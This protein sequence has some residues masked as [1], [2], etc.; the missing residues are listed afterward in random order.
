[1]KK[2]F[3]FFILIIVCN[4]SVNAQISNKSKKKSTQKN[5]QNKLEAPAFPSSESF[6]NAKLTYKIISAPN[7]TWGYDIFKDGS[8]CIH[9]NSIPG[10][11]GINGFATKQK[12]EKV[13]QLIVTKIQNGEMPPTV[14]KEEMK[15]VGAL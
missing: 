9:Q 12:A 1:M 4:I 8:M 10:V 7:N 5:V 14:S 3:L 13:A 15:A 6:K 2:S 11:S